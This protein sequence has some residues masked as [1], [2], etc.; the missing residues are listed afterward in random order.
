LQLLAGTALVSLT[1]PAIALNAAF[2]ADSPFGLGV[3]SGS[4]S[5]DGFVLW[6]RLIGANLPTDRA[7]SVEWEVF[8]DDSLRQSVAQGRALAL[9]ELAHSVHVETSGLQPNQWYFYRFRCGNL[10]SP[11]GR[12]RTLPAANAAVSGLRLAYASCQNWEHGHYAAYRQMRLDK[13]DMVVFLGDYIY[14]GAGHPSPGQVRTHMLPAANSLESYRARYALYKSDP[15]LQAMHAACPWL[16]TWDDHEVENNYAGEF[17]ISAKGLSTRRRQVAYQ[18]YYEHMPLRASTMIRNVEGLRKKG[19]LRIYDTYDYGRLARIYMLDNRQY[20]S[21][22]LCG[23]NPTQKLQTI[24]QAVPD[25]DD[26]RS[27]LGLDQERWLSDKFAE[28]RDHNTI[29]NLISQQTRFTPLNYL[30]GA[31]QNARVDTWDGFPASRQRLIDALVSKGATN[32]IFLGG[33]IHKNWVA[34][35]YRDPYSVSS[36]IIAA[37]Y[38]GTSISSRSKAEEQSDVK[39]MK[40]NPHCLFVNS[41]KRGYGLMDV[42]SERVTVT[43]RAVDDPSRPDSQVSELATFVTRSGRPGVTRLS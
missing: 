41:Q 17:L 5:T 13:P 36:P 8:V 15:A 30:H 38:C 19:A 11:L 4:P 22:P 23:T 43:L 28:A 6:T 39:A 16:V 24:C 14:E 21:A 18:A 25:I 26:E 7:V 37:E 35:V 32:P 27:L 9:P 10:L 2:A 1:K 12:A 29:W 31:G 3:A 33:D 20:R 34:N 40:K 42:S